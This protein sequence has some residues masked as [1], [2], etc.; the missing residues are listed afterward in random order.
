MKFR[1]LYT[2]FMLA[3]TA[4]LFL[5]NS[6][7]AGAIQQQDRTG[8]PL[9]NAPCQACHSS[10]NFNPS[11]TLEILD[12]GEPVTMYTPGETY[13]MRVTAGHTGTPASF[14]FQAVALSGSDN[15]Q[16]GEFSNPPSGTQITNLLGRQYPEHSQRNESNVFEMDW[17]APA[18]GTGEVRFYSAV[19]A[20]NN[21]AGSGGDGSAFLNQPVQLEEGAPS[22]Q[23]DADLAASLRAFP[24]PASGQIQ[25]QWETSATSQQL[26]VEVYRLDGQ[27]VLRQPQQQGAGQQSATLDIS[28]LPAA[29][30]LLRLTDGE[31]QNTLRFV[32]N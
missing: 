29:A 4:F 17:T 30:Y 19:V 7:G 13:K 32:K 23:R 20:A 26:W 2:L 14:G 8:S 1:I 28:E 16:A 11:I 31:R 12:D 25:V 21:G 10:G 24:N 22:S 15:Q 27:R 3:G 5:N 6:S 18:A 9:S